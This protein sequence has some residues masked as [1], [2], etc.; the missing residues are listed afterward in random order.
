MSMEG[1]Q[2]SEPTVPDA[3]QTASVRPSVWSRGKIPLLVAIIGL[4]A[5]V[6]SSWI[7]VKAPLSATIKKGDI[8]SGQIDVGRSEDNYKL[9]DVKNR[10]I[11]RIE[12]KHIK[13]EPAFSAQP[14]VSVALKALDVEKSANLRV[15]VYATNINE[16]GFD[17][18]VQAWGDTKITM[19]EATWLAYEKLPTQAVSQ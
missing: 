2:H 9:F 3:K 6:V 1:E 7:T 8:Q 10:N 11:P 14:Q 15:M 17:F 16:A 13:F 19:V 12:V 18:A 5:S 4:I